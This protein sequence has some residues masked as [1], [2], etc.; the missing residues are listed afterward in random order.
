F[1]DD[2]PDRIINDDAIMRYDENG[3]PYE[4]DWPEVEVIVGNPPLLG[5]Q[6][7]RSELTSEYL[8]HLWE[9]YKGR[10]SGT[11]DLVTYWFER[12]RTQ[13]EQSKAKRAGLLAT[14]SIRGGANREVLERIKATGNIFMAWSDRPWVLEGA[15]VRISIIGFDGGVETEYALD[16]NAVNTINPDLTTQIDITIANQL[17]ENEQLAF[18]GPVKVGPFDIPKEVGEGMLKASNRSGRLNSDVV[19]PYLN[20]D[21]ITKRSRQMWIVDFGSL[22]LDDAKMYEAPFNYV[23]T[24]VKP[25]RAK[26]QDNQRRTYW[27][28]LGRSGDDYREAVSTL[29]R[30]IFSPRVSKHRLFVWVAQNV[31]PS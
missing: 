29:N 15:A 7:L 4:P 31:F 26:N 1:S 10:I 30:Q 8:A 21:D 6:K 24:T 3:K 14:N 27:W 25:V 16:G 19:K 23:E 20:G 2:E 28:R 17:K 12:A 11:A 5:S 9:L 22:S 18:Q 13:I